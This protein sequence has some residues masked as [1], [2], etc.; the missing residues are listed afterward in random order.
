MRETT[1]ITD[2]LAEAQAQQAA[3]Q[4]AIARL[5]ELTA[6]DADDSPAGHAAMKLRP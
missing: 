3:A 5:D 6:D 2:V 1:S 4:A